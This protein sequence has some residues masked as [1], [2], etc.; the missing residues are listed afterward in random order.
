MICCIWTWR[1]VWCLW[2]GVDYSVLGGES[3]WRQ[4]QEEAVSAAATTRRAAIAVQVGKVTW[5]KTRSSSRTSSLPASSSSATVLTSGNSIKR[6]R[7][8]NLLR[9]LRWHYRLQV[10]VVVIISW[11]EFLICLRQGM[12]RWGWICL[13]LLNIVEYRRRWWWTC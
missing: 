3:Y 11:E 1:R 10:G 6:D 4:L 7:I 9:L 8:I 12:A 2:T 13:L 5:R